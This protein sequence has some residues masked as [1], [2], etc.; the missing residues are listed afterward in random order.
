MLAGGDEV[1]TR[2]LG[3]GGR[4]DRG[5]DLKEVVLHHGLAQRGDDVAAQDDVLLHIG[6]AQVQIAVLEPLGLVGLPAAVDLEGQLIVAAAA[7]DGD[8]LRHDLDLAGGHLGGLAGPL[9]DGARHGDGGLLV[10]AIHHV[11]HLFGLYY[12]LSGS[13]EITQNDKSEILADFSHVLEPADQ[14]DSLAN[15]ADPKFITI[16]GS[17]LNHC[18]CSF[19]CCFLSL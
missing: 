11:H 8:L 4:Q 6:V 5:G 19:V 7:Q 15:V 18:F 9:P 3:G 16:M 14:C 10:D 17:G 13:V 12:Q 2:A 1:V